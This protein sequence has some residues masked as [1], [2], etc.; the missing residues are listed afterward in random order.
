M[1]RTA[2]LAI[3]LGVWPWV[4]AGAEPAA[5]RQAEL[6]HLLEHDCG[7]G[8]GLTREGGLG[9]PLLPGDLDGKDVPIIALVILEGVHGTPMPPW[10]SE[11]SDED[12]VWLAAQLKRGYVP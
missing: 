6:L 7:S 3:A 4:A 1:A 11:L 12:A 5:A 8:H 10:K 2:V 9:P